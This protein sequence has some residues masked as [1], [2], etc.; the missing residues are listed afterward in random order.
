MTSA[1]QEASSLGGLGLTGR[2]VLVTGAGRGLGRSYAQALARQGASVVVHDAGVDQEGR[3][4]DPSCARQVAD[5]V[6]EDGGAASAMTGLLGDADSCRQ[7]VEAVVERYGRLDGLIH[8]AGLVIWRDPAQLDEEA[9]KRMADIN[10]DAAFWLCAAALPIMRT[11]GFGRIVLTTSGWALVPHPGSDRLIA[12]S[13]GKAA[14]FGLAMALSKGA[15]HPEILTNAIA[16]VANTRMYSGDVPEGRL[17]PERVAGAVTWLASPAC[18]VTGCVVRASDGELTLARLRD[19]GSRKLGEAAADPAAAGAAI[20][21][22]A[23]DD[24]AASR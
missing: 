11:Q 8:N 19:L 5:G 17:L 15:G 21:A 20:L 3:N 10:A 24:R 12:Y 16:P 23:R 4:P 7:L 9:Y 1:E 2:V 18:A 6:N 22:L 13:H 14:Q